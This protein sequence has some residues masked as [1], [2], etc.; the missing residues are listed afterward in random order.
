M[1]ERFVPESTFAEGNTSAS[2][3]GRLL[4]GMPLAY[5]VKEGSFAFDLCATQGQEVEGLF[6]LADAVANQAF[7]TTATG[8]YLDAHADE[9]GL[10]RKAGTFAQVELTFT[11]TDLTAIPAGTRVTTVA[12]AGVS[13]QPIIFETIA[14]DAIAGTTAIVDAQAVELGVLANVSAGTLIRLEVGIVGISAV[15]NVTAAGGGTDPEDDETLR[16]R[17]LRRKRQGRGAGTAGDYESWA[18]E[19]EGVGFA[20]VERN[21]SG[22]GTVRV[23]LLDPL[24]SPVIDSVKD[25]AEANIQLH[26]PLGTSLTVT[27]PSTAAIAVSSNVDLEPNFTLTSVYADVQTNIAAYLRG[28]PPGGTVYLNEI[29]AVVVQTAGIKDYSTFQIGNPTLG[30][31]NLVMSANTKPILGNVV[32]T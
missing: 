10:T 32:I 27:T 24:T 15:T 6:L 8:S 19:V 16:A 28:V 12:P 14:L 29:A 22:A 13:S 23:I 11:G 21:W 31:S 20:F 4:A 18:T 30:T 26:S 17:V 7:A 9:M 1:A 2:I 5:D 25:A 3:T